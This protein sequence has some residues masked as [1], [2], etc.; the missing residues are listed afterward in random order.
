M[1]LWQRKAAKTLTT[2]INLERESDSPCRLGPGLSQGIEG[3][4]WSP[5]YYVLDL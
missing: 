4:K 5:V 1:A 2:E 3:K